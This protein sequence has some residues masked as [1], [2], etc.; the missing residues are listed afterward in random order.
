M[1]KMELYKVPLTK[2]FKSI[3]QIFQSKIAS[4]IL[5]L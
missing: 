1:L 2:D 5:Y 4:N 3:Q